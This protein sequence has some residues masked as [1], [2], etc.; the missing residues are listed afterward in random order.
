M[1]LN[2]IIW[3]FL[4]IR[5]IQ[6]GGIILP[7]K[8]Y[9]Y[10]SPMSALRSSSLGPGQARMN[11][12]YLSEM[13]HAA[14][15]YQSDYSMWEGLFRVACIIFDQPVQEPV[16]EKINEQIRLQNEDGDYAGNAIHNLAIARAALALYEYALFFDFSSTS[17]CTSGGS[18]KPLKSSAITVEPPSCVC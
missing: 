8:P 9:Y 15:A 12:H 18:K 7:V 17:A 3:I 13:Y 2:G 1:I 16:F 5:K 11:F 4:S 10:R 6:N 14:S